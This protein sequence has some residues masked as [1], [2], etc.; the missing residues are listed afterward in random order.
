M[1]QFSRSSI[2]D[3]LNQERM[4]E[5]ERE[6]IKTIFPVY[7]RKNEVGRY[8]FD[9]LN[10]RLIDLGNGK[11]GIPMDD[12]EKKVGLLSQCQGLQTLVS[13]VNDFGLDFD[14]TGYDTLHHRSIRNI[15]DAILNPLIQVWTR[16]WP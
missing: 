10:N 1:A 11:L 15:M 9:A 12:A 2:H 3:I 5:M 14:D 4:Q 7:R 6:G 16:F 13:L 8:I